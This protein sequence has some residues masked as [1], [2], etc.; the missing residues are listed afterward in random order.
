MP[1]ARRSTYR[2]GFVEYQSKRKR[3]T[4]ILANLSKQNF[5]ELRDKCNPVFL[6]RN[7]MD[8]T[9]NR[10]LPRHWV[11]LYTMMTHTTCLMRKRCRVTTGVPA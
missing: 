9:L 11:P 1:R 7:K 2:R 6:A 8:I 4:D 10:V 5:V 3:D